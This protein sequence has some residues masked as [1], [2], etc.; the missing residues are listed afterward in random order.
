MHELSLATSLLELLEE[1]A[2]LDAFN[3]VQKIV[4]KVGELSGV[5]IPA[6]RQ[7]FEFA[8]KGTLAEGAKM[9]I[10]EPPGSGWCFTCE[11]TVPLRDPFRSCPYCGKSA[12]TPT[13]GM[14]FMVVELV[15]L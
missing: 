9:D 13:G 1:R 3:R 8:T 11:R 14:E 7:G 10:I 5:S 12:V 6:L 2:L 4:L 15:V